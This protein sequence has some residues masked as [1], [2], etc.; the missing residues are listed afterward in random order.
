MAEEIKIPGTSDEGVSSGR[1]LVYPS[2]TGDESAWFALYVQVNHEKE[3]AKRLEQKSID[4]FLPLMESWSKRK[5]RR[6]K[7]RV[8]LF[9]GY[10]FIHT[11]LDNYTNVN[12]LKTPGAITIL[13]NSEGPLPI[14]EQQ[15]QSLQTMLGAGCD[16]SLHHYLK[17]GDWVRVRRGPLSGC[18]GLLLRHNPKKGRLVV[19]I[20][21]IKQS[22]AVELD[23]EDVE[24]LP[25]SAN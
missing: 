11:V 25:G 22:V 17:E 5:D 4:A 6:K 8:P 2:L 15:I 10:V 7:I 12:V 20:D 24:L 3:V 21:I 19:S 18:V 16:L 9:P 14:P 13:R 1:R 23:I